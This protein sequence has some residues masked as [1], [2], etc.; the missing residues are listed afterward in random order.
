MFI[1]IATIENGTANV[2]F[3]SISVSHVRVRSSHEYDYLLQYAVYAS[4]APYVYANG[5]FR[6]GLCDRFNIASW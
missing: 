3:D 5:P 2:E 1:R 6:I 4:G